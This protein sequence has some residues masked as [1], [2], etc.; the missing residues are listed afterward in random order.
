[1]IN[2]LPPQE[3]AALKV[4]GAKRLTAV[5][6]FVIIISLVS[7]GLVLSA[8]K[9]YVLESISYHQLL[10]D[11]MKSKYE[12]PDFVAFRQI[13][14]KYNAAIGQVNS[15][16]LDQPSFSNA[17]KI[18]AL[19]ARPEGLYFTNIA[20]DRGEKKNLKVVLSG[21]SNTRDNLVL[22]KEAIEKDVRIKNVIF[23]AANWIK[24]KDVDF[25]LTFEVHE[26]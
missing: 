14:Q 16:Y 24:A 7:L 8:V 21:V 26:D 23:P 17:V 11:S 5:F 1:M 13:I 22:F 18:V 4:E 9:F 3:K 12:T 6:G 25:S 19:I 20:F 2:L 15:F 10:L